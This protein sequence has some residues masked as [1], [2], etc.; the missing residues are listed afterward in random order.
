VLVAITL[1]LP[2]EGTG[3]IQ[4]DGVS[5]EALLLQ[6]VRYPLCTQSCICN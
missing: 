6:S 1:G 5:V 3:G 2:G 4:Q